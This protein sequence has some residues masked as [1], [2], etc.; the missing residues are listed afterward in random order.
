MTDQI[1]R[2]MYHNGPF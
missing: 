1:L 2:P